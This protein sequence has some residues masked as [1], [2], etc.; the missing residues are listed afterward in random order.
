MKPQFL[1]SFLV[2]ALSLTPAAPA[3]AQDLERAFG[4]LLGAII[5]GAIQEQKSQRKRQQNLKT[6]EGKIDESCSCGHLRRSRI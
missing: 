1:A 4:A 2:I 3:Q 6:S 5:G